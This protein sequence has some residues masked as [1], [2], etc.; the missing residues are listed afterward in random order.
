M[1]G[2]EATLALDRLGRNHHRL[3]A[4]QNRRGLSDFGVAGAEVAGFEYQLASQQ[5]LG[6]LG[7]EPAAIFGDADGY[8]FILIFIDGIENRCGGE[9]RDFVFAAAA[10]KKNPHSK[11]FHDPSVWTGTSLRVNLCG[12]SLKVLIKL[13]C[14]ALFAAQSGQRIHT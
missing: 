10:A 2:N 11:L 7:G 9:Q 14:E 12:G 1:K 8:D 4:R 3:A 5:I 6:V 13:I